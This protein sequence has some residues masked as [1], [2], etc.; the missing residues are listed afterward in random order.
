MKT[1]TYRSGFQ[2]LNI[3]VTI[4]S[5]AELKIWKAIFS[6]VS[7]EDVAEKSGVEDTDKIF[8]ILGTLNGLA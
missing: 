1:T 5:E 4:E 7:M 2:P 3:A 8:S 6:S